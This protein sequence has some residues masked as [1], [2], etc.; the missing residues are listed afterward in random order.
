MLE[1]FKALDSVKLNFSPD[2]LF[3]LNLTIAFIMFGVALELK[4]VHFRNLALNP[5]AAVV[6]AVSQ[7]I[8]MPL[9]TFLLALSFRNYI[10][11]TIGLGMILV[12]SC[13]GGNVSNFFSALARG[14]VALSVSLTAIS[15]FGAILITPFNFAFWGTLFTKVYSLLNASELVRPLEIPFLHVLQ[16]VV[17]LLGIPLTLG[18][19]I[20]IYLPKL[21][22][23]ILI[24]VKRLSLIAFG[25]IIAIMFLKNWEFFLQYIKYIFVIVFI[26]N[27]LALTLGWSFASVFRLSYRDRKT[28]S[29][30]TG[31]QNS[32]L[33]LLLLFNP[34]IFPPDMAVGGL[35]FIAAWW[36]LWHLVAGLVMGGIW[37]GF[38]LTPKPA[39]A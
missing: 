7:F 38:R 33:A 4:P 8:M 22:D 37:S 34:N 15:D 23:K 10:T 39:V 28:I 25:A 12:A 35:A 30:E 27:A 9:M 13:P 5:K 29:I 18:M 6:G 16:T 17:I 21:T 3:V 32:G 20:N 1:A 36:G 19:L 24:H 14:N 26:H 31:I 2:S 11:P